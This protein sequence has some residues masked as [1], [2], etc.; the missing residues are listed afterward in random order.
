MSRGSSTGDDNVF[1]VP[2]RL[3]GLEPAILRIPVFASDFGR[4]W[5]EPTGDWRVVFP[6]LSDA[7]GYR[8]I[9]AAELKREYPKTFAHLQQNV[10]K[11]KARKQFKQWFGYS[12]PR[13]LQLHDRAQI[14]VPLLAEKGS[15]TLIPRQLQRKLC[16]MASGG[17]SITLLPE[18]D[19][20]PEFVLG[21][22]NSKLLFWF[23]RHLSNV[24]RGNWITCTKQYFGELPIVALDL[25]KKADKAAHD[26]MVALVDKM[27]G[28]VPKLRKAK[29]EAER[30][31]LQN[32]V[33]AT[34]RAID[35]LVY[36]LYGLTADEI[37]P[38]EGNA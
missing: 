21:V 17:F 19:L 25:T 5:F 29:T 35:Q 6:Y 31:T 10:L 15:F 32:A 30:R 14:I 9:T 13:N 38:V 23:L 37:R 11:L 16:P 8:L 1:V 36:K 2:F 4:Y 34:D 27:L 3:H 28:L 7:E 20:K 26:E 24:F 18:C 22:L 33:A 12:A